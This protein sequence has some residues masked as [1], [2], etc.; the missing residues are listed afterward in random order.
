MLTKIMNLAHIGLAVRDLEKCKEF[1]SVALTPLGIALLK[2][3][4]DSVH[5]GKKDE[6]RTMLWLHTRGPVPG[7][8][9]IAFEA[10][11]REQ[12]DAFHKAALA[13]GGK[14]NGAPGVRENYSPDYYAAFV[15]DPEGH[16]M[17]AV[18]R[19]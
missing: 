1:Y 2:E 5:F 17:E 6:G 7:P 9:H 10:D 13:V 11:T 19:A 4:E 16:N 14:D 15:I 3:K 18:C 8:I 12:V